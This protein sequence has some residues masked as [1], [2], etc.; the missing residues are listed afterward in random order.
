VIAVDWGTSSLRCY[1]LDAEGAILETRTAAKG[2]L[3]VPAGKF[4]EVLD[5]E[6]AGWTGPVVMSGMVG[7]RQGWMEAPYVKCPAGF[8]EIA[9]GL[10]QVRWGDRSAWIVPGVS[11][12][13]AAGVPDVMRGEETQLLE[14]V[15]L[16]ETVAHFETERVAR[17]G[18]ALPIALS[19]SPIRDEHRRVIGSAMIAHDISAQRRADRAMRALAGQDGVGGRVGRKR[20]ATQG[21]EHERGRNEA[22]G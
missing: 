2:I 7:S 11:C 19:L 9:E 1:R 16:G 3:A 17:G 6:I 8:D 18:K 5:E 10:Q 13:D 20:R 15:R 21:G 22:T 4:S 12:R 14:Q